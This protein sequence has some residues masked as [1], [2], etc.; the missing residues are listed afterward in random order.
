MS[1]EMR[2]HI[3]TFKKFLLKENVLVKIGDFIL[4]KDDLDSKYKD[5]IIKHFGEY[6]EDTINN[7]LWTLYDIE[8]LYNNGGYIYRVIWLKNEKDFNINNLGNHWLSNKGDIDNIISLFTLRDN[9]KGYPY[10]IKAYTPPKNVSIP[11]DYFNNIE[12]NEVLV[13]NDKLLSKI[14]LIKY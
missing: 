3:D 13:I 2:E 7:S 5:K 9:V 1:K 14:E 12:E 10:Y 4:T 11:Y 6:N 8:N